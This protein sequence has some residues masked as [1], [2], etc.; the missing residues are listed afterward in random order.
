MHI[1]SRKR[2]FEFS[3]KHQDSEGPLKRWW[4]ICTKNNYNSFSELKKT[5]GTAD[6]VNKCVIFNISGG[7]YR[8]IV[9]TNFIAQRMWIKYILLHKKYEKLNLKEDPKC[10]P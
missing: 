7:K 4:K 9:R 3:I 6:M 2:L 8:L 1:I 5:F 10:L